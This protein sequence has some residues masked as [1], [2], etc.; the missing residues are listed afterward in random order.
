M[1]FFRTVTR[2]P[3]FVGLLLASAGTAFS[4]PGFAQQA[5]PPRLYAPASPAVGKSYDPAGATASGSTASDAGAS[6][7]IEGPQ[8]D[9]QTKTGSH[10]GSNSADAS[11]S[12]H[13]KASP[14]SGAADA[15]MDDRKAFFSAR[16]AAL[17][18][19]LTLNAD[20]EALWAPVETAIR[21]LEKS[22]HARQT[23]EGIASLLRQSPSD[24]LRLR[25][26]QLSQRGDAMRKLAEAS[27]PLLGSL[28]DGQKNRLPVLLVGMRPASILRAAFDIRYGQVVDDP[29]DASGSSDA[30]Q[31]GNDRSSPHQGAEANDGEGSSRQDA[32]SGSGGA[33]LD[34]D[35]DREQNYGS[36]DRGRDPM[37]H[38]RRRFDM[39][40]DDRL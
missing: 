6:T 30:R 38:Q 16:L 7:K 21:N 4:S 40:D 12:D 39:G 1:P 33:N 18:A 24:L 36:D 9:G 8:A 11:D 31:S 34:R 14:T 3:T 2:T 19:G 10:G 25:G 27:V 13:S 35:G 29:D 37:R 5:Q 15:R 17:H 22:R 20:Q 26:E 23:R 28:D 32:A